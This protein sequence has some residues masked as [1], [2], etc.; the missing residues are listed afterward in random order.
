MKKKSKATELISF[1]KSF[2]DWKEIFKS[3]VL[4]LPFISSKDNLTSANWPVLTE[5]LIKILTFKNFKNF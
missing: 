1:E 5:L 3:A 2:K 4:V